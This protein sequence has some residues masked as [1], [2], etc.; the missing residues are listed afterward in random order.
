MSSLTSTF[1]HKS[2]SATFLMRDGVT[3]VA[4]PI[5]DIDDW[6]YYNTALCIN[7]G[8]QVGACFVMLVV[9]AVLTKESK[10]RT[11]VYILNLL[12]GGVYVLTAT[13]GFIEILSLFHLLL[14][15]ASFLCI[16]FAALL[17]RN[18]AISP[19]SSEQE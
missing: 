4:V 6:F 5:S 8:S 13:S 16:G 19:S 14:A 7:Y 3:P 10:R 9:T 18:A 2:Q 11:P 12:L 17:A 15:S 1:D